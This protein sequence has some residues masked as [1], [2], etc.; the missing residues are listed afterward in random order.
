MHILI[1]PLSWDCVWWPW[2][3]DN[4]A[5]PSVVASCLNSQR[6]HKVMTDQ[7]IYFTAGDKS[8]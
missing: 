1:R 5:I 8:S 2:L 4:Q 7:W 6:W 3:P